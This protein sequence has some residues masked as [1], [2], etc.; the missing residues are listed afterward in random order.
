MAKH[1]ISPVQVKAFGG[2]AHLHVNHVVNLKIKS[3]VDPSLSGDMGIFVM[4]GTLIGK[5]EAPSGNMIIMLPLS[6]AKQHNIELTDLVNPR[7]PEPIDIIIGQDLL[8]KHFL[9]PL[10]RNII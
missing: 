5:L 3:K 4:P 9:L 1:P 10:Q 7:Q 8:S 2:L 6:I